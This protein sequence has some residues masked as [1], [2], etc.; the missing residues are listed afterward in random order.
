MCEKKVEIL[1]AGIDIYCP[2]PA[3][4]AQVKERLRWFCGRTQMDIEGLG[5]RLIDRLVEQKL[6][7]TFAD[8]YRLTVE[9]V[10]SLGSEVLQNEKSVKRTT[11]E[12]VA[13]K[14]VANIAA[15]K[16]RPLERLIAGLGIHHVGTRVGHVLANSFGS[17]DALQ[18][19]STETLAATNEIGEVIAESVHDFFHS[20][21]GTMTIADLQSV[22]VD[23]TVEIAD[24]TELAALPLAGMSIVVTGTL[25][26]MKRPEIEELITKLGGKPSGSVS[27]KTAFLVAGEEAGSKLAKAKELGIEVLNEEQFLK[28]A[29]V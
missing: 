16:Q 14:I 4:P 28:R 15:S 27:K 26:T 22:G 7:I 17:L 23:P 12:K 3:C 20:K 6:V 29:K 21:T 24:P 19:A 13:T 1:D 9:S 11:G 25:P 5:D 2:N 8:L 10:A 18:K